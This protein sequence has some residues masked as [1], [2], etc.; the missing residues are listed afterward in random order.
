[1][2]L[3][4]DGSLGEWTA[5][6]PATGFSTWSLATGG[7][8]WTVTKPLAAFKPGRLYDMYGWTN[9]D[10]ASADGPEFTPEELSA[11]KPGEVLWEPPQNGTPAVT[12]AYFRQH[13]CDLYD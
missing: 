8:G 1:L 5:N 11:L 13:A 12:L 2:G 7:N 10:S 3:G 6:R 9:N 4:A